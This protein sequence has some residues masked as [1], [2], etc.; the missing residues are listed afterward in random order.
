MEVTL[1][2]KSLLHM[3]KFLRPF[4]IRTF[5]LGCRTDTIVEGS[6]LFSFLYHL[7]FLLSMYFTVSVEMCV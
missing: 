2:M 1:I 6:V 5:F 3:H 7:V 4:Q